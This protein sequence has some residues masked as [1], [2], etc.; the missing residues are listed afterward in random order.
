ML[1]YGLRLLDTLVSGGRQRLQRRLHLHGRRR[2]ALLRATRLRHDRLG[3][4]LAVGERQRLQRRLHLH[5]RRRRAL[6][7]A[8]RLRHDRLGRR[9]AVCER[10]RLQHRLHLHGRRRF[11]LLHGRLGRAAAASAPTASA[12]P[13]T[14]YSRP[15]RAA[16]RRGRA[17]AASAPTASAWPSGGSQRSSGSGFSADGICMAV[18]GVLFYG[19]RVLGTTVSG[20][21]QRLQRRLHVHGRRRR[22]PRRATRLRHGRLGRLLAVGKRQRLQRRLHLHGRR[23]RALLRATRL[24]HDRLGRRLAVCER[25]RLQHRLHLHGRRRFALLHGRLGRAAAASAP[26]A[27]A[28]PSTAYS[29]PS[30]A[31]HRRGR[32][33]AASAP[34]ASAWPSG[35]SQR[36]SGSGFS[37]DC[38]CMAVDGVL[39][40]GLAVASPPTA[41]A[42]PSTACSS[43]RSASAARPSLRRPRSASSAPGALLRWRFSL[44]ACGALRLASGRLWPTPARAVLPCA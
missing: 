3:R 40:Y 36:A 9:L 15:S 32:A 10:Q 20:G 2:R 16:H 23:R 38:I 5:G 41:S 13:S 27:S 37:A 43:T 31:A 11:A 30:R 22:A 7:R 4:R 12:W 35:G 19:L 42:E 44:S 21:R 29:R 33:A 26:T 17:A 8:T 24:R 14:A 34:S 25:Q 1:F 6:L 39:F 28:W 18:D